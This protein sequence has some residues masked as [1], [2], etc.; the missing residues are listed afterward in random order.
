MTGNAAICGYCGAPLRELVDGTCPFCRTPVVAD[1]A[2]QLPSGHA[3]VLYPV[4]KR[5][6]KVIKAVLTCT[7]IDLAV[8]KR[9]VETADQGRAVIATGLALADAQAYADEIN[10]AG[11]R[12]DVT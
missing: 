1:V 12:A 3:V 4:G 7:H 11:G 10:Q 2:A 6:I 9:L 5:K 8:A